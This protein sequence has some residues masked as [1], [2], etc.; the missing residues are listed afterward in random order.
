VAASTDSV[1]LGAGR[2]A[3][4]EV[5]GDGEPLIYFTGGPGE[6]AAVLR[7][8]AG[9]LSDRFAV[10]LIEPHGSGGSSPPADP[11]LYDPVG[12]ARFYEDV[13]RA[14]GIERATIMGFS[15][16]ATVAL[17]YAA[18]FPTV[19]RRC[20]AVSARAVGEQAGEESEAEMERALSR[21]GPAAWY[22]SA[23][24]VWDEWTERTLIAEDAAELDAMMLAVLPLYL[25]HPEGP[26]AKALVESWR[27]NLQTNLAAAKAWEGGLWKTLDIRSLLAR[28]DCPAL[29]L[30]G[31]LDLICGPTH[32][33]QIA[34][35]IPEAEVV[36]VPDCGHFIPGE[37]PDRF[38]A[39]VIA[40]CER[41]PD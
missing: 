9:R 23:R 33:R 21:H 18:L 10:H 38:R 11:S 1:D 20:I 37:A 35:A 13:R 3:A 6:N 16:G 14:L 19:T 40:F 17:T 41:D 28:I 8:D 7:D 29:L 5:I 32:A 24:K 30:V 36:I 4:Y 12:H 27:R 15:F 31:A 34:Q 39:E 25:A 22:P 26:A 2:R